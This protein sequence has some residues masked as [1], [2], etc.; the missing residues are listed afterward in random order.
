MPWP[1][2]D[3]RL[4][5]RSAVPSPACDTHAR[6]ANHQSS[7]EKSRR[8]E[9]HA[10][11]GMRGSDRRLVDAVPLGG[12][13]TK[14]GGEIVH[15]VVDVLGPG[16]LASGIPRFHPRDRLIDEQGRAAP[17]EAVPTVVEGS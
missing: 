14:L 1:P 13:K 8:F 6:R 10:F 16:Q 2:G 11:K 5:I 15:V 3:H 9:T 17:L 12:G 4:S 7:S